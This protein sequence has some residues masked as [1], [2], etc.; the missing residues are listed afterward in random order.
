MCG[1]A[2][3]LATKPIDWSKTLGRMADRLGHRGP[4]DYGIW[5]D[6]E[7][8]IGLA[9]RR[10][11]IL[12][13]S[14]AGK[15]PMHSASQRFVISYN[16]E[17]YNF[18]ELQ[19]QLG[20]TGSSL[21][22][23]R[24]SSDTE[25]LLAAIE[26]WGLRPAIQRCRGMFA[27][28]LWDRTERVLHLVRDRV[29]EKPLYYGWIGKTLMFA[30]ELK[31]FQAFENFT[32][33]IDRQALAAYMQY[34]Y[35]PTPQTIFKGI[36]KLEPGTIAS[37]SHRDAGK[38]PVPVK[39]WSANEI[40]DSGVADQFKGSDSDAE[41]H[42]DQLLRNSIG[43][44]MI[45]DVPLGAFLSG[46]IDSSTVVALMQDISQR[47]VKTFTIGFDETAY[48]ESQDAAAV[49]KHLRTDHTELIVTADD[50]MSVIPKLPNLYDEP[51]A[52]SSQLPTYLVSA[53]ARQHV[54]VSL[55]GDGGDELLGGYNRHAWVDKIWA[56]VGRLPGFSRRAFA[57]ATKTLSP[58]RWDSI[59][60]SLGEVLPS[61]LSPRMPGQKLHKLAGVIDAKSPEAM[62]RRLATHWHSPNSIV[63]GTNRAHGATNGRHWPNLGSTAQEIMLM[64][65]V[66][67]LPDDI[68]VKV[69]RAAMGVSLETRVPFLDHPIIEFAWRLPLNMKIRDGEGKWLLRQV[70]D[71]YV[72]RTLM[73][74]P[75]AG[76]GIPID[77]WLRGPLKDWAE[78][79]LGEQR[80]K[81][82]GYLNPSPI[83]KAWR[84]HLTGTRSRQ[85][86]L[87]T[88]LMFQSWL[89]SWR[90]NPKWYDSSSR[91]L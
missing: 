88:I 43:L 54:T 42:L 91:V 44:Q 50:A 8:G 40:A 53:L 47:P 11:S 46:G 78:D 23:F 33:E 76:F 22:K 72:P 80:L 41:N 74:R 36:R 77:D 18:A 37:V 21:V 86:E 10:L 16:G 59:F 66:T 73:E 85:H 82:E 13:L 83:R 2:G 52:D 49:A 62:Y 5:S 3:I 55:S 34:A 24:G 84:E 25:V 35:V 79:L 65:L 75:K 26:Q 38:F 90:G 15:Q 31:A 7:A 9:H 61:R 71:R 58:D 27:F 30:S 17:I 64:D 28:A 67:Y 20:D 69:D 68:L 56:R 12:D 1:I 39:Y 81:N 4:D 60:E 89:E 6:P 45:A 57:H 63:L 48:D 29:G 70:L 32:P 87:W 51:F 19:K 14:P